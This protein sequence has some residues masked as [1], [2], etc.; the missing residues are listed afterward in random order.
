CDPMNPCSIIWFERFGYLTI[1]TM[2][3]SGFAAI[4]AM[5]AVSPTATAT[6]PPSPNSEEEH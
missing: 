3:L 4:I 6:R 1:P 2:A 5:L